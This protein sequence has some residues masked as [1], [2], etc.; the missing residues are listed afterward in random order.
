MPQNLNRTT[1]SSFKFP[2]KP[3]NAF[4]KQPTKNNFLQHFFKLTFLT[5]KQESKIKPMTE[6]SPPHDH[7]RRFSGS[8][9]ENWDQFEGLLWASIA[10][11]RIPEAH[12]QRARYLHLH[13]DENS[14]NFFFSR[15]QK[16][17]ETTWKTHESYAT[18]MQGQIKQEITS[19]NKRTT[20]RFS[21]WPTT[22]RKSCKSRRRRRWR[23]LR[24]H[25]SQRRIR[26][27]FIQGMPFKQEGSSERK[28]QN[29]SQRAVRNNQKKSS[30]RQNTF[31]TIAHHSI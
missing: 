5:H 22:A 24:S 12:H 11:S 26:K 15:S 28:W 13:L 30:N 31:R 3:P 14:H 1:V 20:G 19:T 23:R 7:L 4:W 9:N 6:P 27:Q 29:W 18:A 17:R 25:E 16:L 2:T 21:H 10:V 8:P